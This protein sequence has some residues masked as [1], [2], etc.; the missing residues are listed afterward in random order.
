M[1]KEKSD[2]NPSHSGRKYKIK[3]NVTEYKIQ[4]TDLQ[5]QSPRCLV[6]NES[7]GE[8][9][10]NVY[11]N[12]ADARHF[13]GFCVRLSLHFSGQMLWTNLSFSALRLSDGSS[14]S[15][16][17]TSKGQTPHT[18]TDRRQF[19]LSEPGREGMHFNCF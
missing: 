15:F 2:R 13:R 10:E 9:L 4:R 11:R 8:R 1:T 12:R 7:D 6:C 16:I 17:S 18:Q 14:I 19:H 5:T 3:K